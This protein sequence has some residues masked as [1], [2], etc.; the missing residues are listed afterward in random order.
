MSQISH[1]HNKPVSNYKINALNAFIF[2]EIGQ[3]R[4]RHFHDLPKINCEKYSLIK[5]HFNEWGQPSTL[6]K[7]DI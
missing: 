2:R 5:V 1:R 6:L 7:S 3:R 4:N